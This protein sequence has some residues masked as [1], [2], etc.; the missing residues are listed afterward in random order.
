MQCF[1]RSGH[2]AVWTTAAGGWGGVDRSSGSWGGVDHSSGRRHA[3]LWMP[4]RTL[5]ARSLHRT[6]P[7]SCRCG[8]VPVLGAPSVS[9][10]ELQ[11]GLPVSI[12]RSLHLRTGSP[13]GQGRPTPAGQEEP[14]S[15][16]ALM[17]GS[18]QRTGPA[19]RPPANAEPCGPRTAGHA[20]RAGTAAPA[21]GRWAPLPAASA[22]PR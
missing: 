22:P 10:L 20:A 4:P 9:G 5:S 12:P 1:L 3:V 8:Q 19:R 2:R 14:E 15:A 17:L 13:S 11:G 21:P 18:V 7:C 16:G 6:D